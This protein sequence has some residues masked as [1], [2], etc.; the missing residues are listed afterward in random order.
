MNRIIP[1]KDVR[2][3][4]VKPQKQVTADQ[5]VK[6]WLRV[7]KQCYELVVVSFLKFSPSAPAELP[8]TS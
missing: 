6:L 4:G 3:K 2:M 8:V 5:L 7:V 1:E